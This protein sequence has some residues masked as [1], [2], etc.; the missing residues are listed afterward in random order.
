MDSE[1][2][3]KRY[4]GSTL[5]WTSEANRFLVAE[6]AAL[7]PARALDLACGEG[8]NAV[9]LAERGW[10]VTGVDFSKV[11]LEKARALAQARGVHA[12]WVAAD[13]LEYGPEPSAF[14]LVIVFYL[15]VPARRAQHD[16]RPRA[17][18][19]AAGGTFLL[20]GHDSANIEHGHGGPQDPAVLYTAH[21]IVRDL[22]GSGLEIERAERVRAT[23]RDPGRSADRSRRARAGLAIGLTTGWAAGSPDGS[24]RQPRAIADAAPGLWPIMSHS[25]SPAMKR[26]SRW[27]RRLA[28]FLLVVLALL[29]VAGVSALVIRF[30]PPWLVST[31]GLTGTARL[32]ELSRVRVALV[33]IVVAALVAA[34]VDLRVPDVLARPQ[35][36]STPSA[37]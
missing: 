33:L 30:A 16:R 5:L 10:R 17:A 34:V 13:L 15:Q 18:A 8:R 22:R 28:G 9:W 23:G 24:A 26:S 14:G 35:A 4:R 12:D 2:W 31:K 20:V 6:A 3:D 36:S 21:D 1:A 29:A 32:N 37:S 19:V 7:A 11:G 25:S 27:R